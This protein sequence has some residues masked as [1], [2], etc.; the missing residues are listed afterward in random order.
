MN[1]KKIYKLIGKLSSVI[2]FGI[3][4]GV[5]GIFL[6]KYGIEEA[7]NL[8]KGEALFNISWRFIILY[9]AM[10]LQIIIHE[11]G[12]L[13]FGLLSG[14]KFSS[15]R[16]FN[17]MWVK[18]DGHIT[19]KRLSIAGTGGQCLMS[20]PELSDGKIP[21]FLYN[22]GGCIMNALTGILFGMLAIATKNNTNLF[23]VFIIL[24]IVGIGYVVVNGLPL[25]GTVNNDGYNALSLSKDKEAM[26][27]FWI[28][29]KVNELIST[30]N[31]RIKDMP[32]DLFYMPEEEKL[33]NPMIASVGAYYCNY[34]MDLHKFEE[35]KSN[36]EYIVEKSTGII[37]IH[38]ALLKGDL[39]Y[40]HLLQNEK[41]EAKRIMEDK[42]VK[43]I[44]KAMKKFPSV[45]R[46][47]YAYAKIVEE[48]EKKAEE[49][50]KLFQK[51]SKTYPHQ[52]DI[53]SELELMELI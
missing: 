16:I 24:A 7:E 18:K 26:K 19:L 30:E 45:I 37:D 11:S 9:I 6:A 13:I 10:L 32:K 3:M 48:N 8:S 5:C 33:N 31:K 51:I 53:D 25:M 29:M 34:L 35:A 22:M 12:H 46:T 47:E 4:G 49:K 15:F 40:I 43:Q 36:I 23:F 52:S 1:L 14:Y 20:P 27:A 38:S 42:K 21:V 41:E 39:A 44:I 2:I 28:T 50:K 17:F